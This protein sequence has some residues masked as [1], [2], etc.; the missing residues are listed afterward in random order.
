MPPKKSK[1]A[2]SKKQQEK[3][4]QNNNATF[5]QNMITIVVPQQNNQISIK[6]E[7]PH[8]AVLHILSFITPYPLLFTY[9]R[10]CRSFNVLIERTIFPSVHELH[11]IEF[12]SYKFFSDATFTMK[13]KKLS[14]PSHFTSSGKPFDAFCKLLKRTL[15]NV[16]HLIVHSDHAFKLH[17]MFESSVD[18]VSVIC[19]RKPEITRS[20]RQIK[21]PAVKKI[22]LYNYHNSQHVIV[23][24]KT[25]IINMY[26]SMNIN[27]HDIEITANNTY[28]ETIEGVCEYLKFFKSL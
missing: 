23:A 3:I 15:C 11:A 9:R 17:K 26:Y 14:H 6:I 28:K 21:L 27:R 10:V 2:L 1:K 5:N 19:T 4:E 7:L 25:K 12:D 16:K 22:N 13:W 24:D 8:D 18:T 20:N